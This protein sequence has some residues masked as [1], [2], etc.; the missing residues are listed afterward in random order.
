MGELFFVLKSFGL[1]LL[2]LAALQFKVGGETL[3]KKTVRW[4]ETSTVGE[5]LKDVADGAIKLSEKAWSQAMVAI[6]VKSNKSFGMSDWK[7][8]F[9]QKSEEKASK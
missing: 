8:E 2:L 3:E 1:A 5:H 7:V 6:G 9:K 4:I